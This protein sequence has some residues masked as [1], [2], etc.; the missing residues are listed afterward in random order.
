MR[1]YRKALYKL[2]ATL[3]LHCQKLLANTELWPADWLSVLEKKNQ[4]TLVLGI[5]W[6]ITFMLCHQN[7]Y[8]FAERVTE[9]VDMH[10]SDPWTKEHS[11][12]WWIPCVQK[13]CLTWQISLNESTC[14]ERRAN[15][16]TDHLLGPPVIS[17][18]LYEQRSCYIE[19]YLV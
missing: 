17:R 7:D 12:F 16:S 2:S 3:S 14:I 18:P 8:P 10:K 1:N 15:K 11:R 5:L 13:Q 4:K 6:T 9:A 19:S